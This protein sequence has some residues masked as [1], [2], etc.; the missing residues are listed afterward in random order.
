MNTSTSYKQILL[1]SIQL[2][3]SKE[4]KTLVVQTI[5][6]SMSRK[7]REDDEHPVWCFC[8]KELRV[9]MQSMNC[10][11]CGNY[12]QIRYNF[13]ME[14]KIKHIYCN[15]LKHQHATNSLVDLLR[16]NKLL[17]LY[18]VHKRIHILYRAALEYVLYL[19]PELHTFAYTFREYIGISHH[20]L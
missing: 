17:Q 9:Q 10:I 18:Y 15:D 20:S 2:K 4:L 12:I 11:F 6:N 7:S 8:E 19:K 13:D 14:R 16:V 1:K 5:N 3:E